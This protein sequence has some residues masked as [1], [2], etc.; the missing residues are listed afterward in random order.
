MGI[1][2]FRRKHSW[3]KTMRHTFTDVHNW[4]AYLYSRI[5]CWSIIP[6]GTATCNSSQCISG[7]Y[8]NVILFYILTTRFRIGPY[9]AEWHHSYFKI[10]F[11]L[12][13]WFMNRRSGFSV[14]VASGLVFSA[15]WV[16]LGLF[17]WRK[18]HVRG[19]AAHV[20]KR[21]IHSMWAGVSN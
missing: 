7:T 13:K 15:E 4:C 9:Y 3:P 16:Q 18:S 17:I 10:W 19:T 20:I 12:C 8:L 2:F 1:F 5:Q 11:S 14:Q 21:F 6:M